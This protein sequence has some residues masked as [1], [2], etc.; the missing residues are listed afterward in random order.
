MLASAS[1]TR[2]THRRS[3]Q[4]PRRRPSARWIV[5]HLSVE[6]AL[7]LRTRR[8]NRR[9]TLYRPKPGVRGAV[10][11]SFAPTKDIDI[12]DMRREARSRA[13]YRATNRNP[14]PLCLEIRASGESRISSEPLAGLVIPLDHLV[15]RQPTSDGWRARLRTIG[16]INYLRCIALP[17]WYASGDGKGREKP[18]A[19]RRRPGGKARRR[20]RRGP[21]QGRSGGHGELLGGR[22]A[23]EGRK[24]GECSIRSKR[25][26]YVT[27]LEWG[28]GRGVGVRIGD[29]EPRPPGGERRRRRLSTWRYLG[30]DPLSSGGR[31]GP[32]FGD[33]PR[34]WVGAMWRQCGGNVAAM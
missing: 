12:A 2:P 15:S 32:R 22:R 18:M 23:R 6:A 21:H 29:A 9:H 33:E 34:A 1:S 5:F 13:T 10:A 7:L 16:L 3:P 28:R 14:S 24:R 17:S 26:I 4:P 25:S 31:H 19:D 20:E 30:G 27:E 11:S 8:S